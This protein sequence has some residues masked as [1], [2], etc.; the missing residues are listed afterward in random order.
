MTQLSGKTVF[1]TGGS[2]YVGRNLIRMLKREGA[3]VRALA[4]SEKSE[5]IVQHLGAQPVAG[6]ILDENALSAGLAGADYLIHAA[7]DTSHSAHGAAQRRTNIDGTS[8][9]YRT[10]RHHRITRALQ[11]STESVLLAGRPLRN[12]TEELPIPDVL[13][14][15]Y[16]RTKAEA[17]RIALAANDP[18][19]SVV[20]IRPRFVWGRDD[21]TALKQLVDA[22]A[23]GRLVWIAGGTYLTSTTHI[24]N[25]CH[26][27]LL[28]LRKGRPGEVYFLSDGDPV[29]FRDFVSRMLET[30]GVEPPVRSVP[31]FAV[32]WLA[33]AGA[34]ASRVT[35]GRLH[36]PVSLQ[37][38][39]TVGV[40]VTLDI[41]KAR[42]E[43]GY[44][45]QVSREEGL[46]GLRD[47][48]QRSAA[49][50]PETTV[51]A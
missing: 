36:G 35:G 51:P 44:E 1:I 45:P 21:T 16:S 32:K 5:Q 50:P 13:G 23:S 15:G 7:A 9:L 17:E 38:Y 8:L 2:G 24:D 3:D 49:S 42:R 10:A 20:V 30:Q 12:A 41:G 33:H 26:G 4:R 22:C 25:L 29:P 28:A 6:D 48:K 11:L 47:R 39:A 31:R 46:R 18:D 34:L 27:A 40:E 43:L 14:G 19:M 37:E